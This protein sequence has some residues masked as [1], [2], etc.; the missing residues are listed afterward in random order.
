M[1]QPR[2]RHRKGIALLPLGHSDYEQTL[3]GLAQWY[4][5]SAACSGCGRTVPVDRYEMRRR[6]GENKKV[7]TLASKLVCSGCGNRV[8][9]KLLI[10]MMPRD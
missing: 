7:G 10:G 2:M 6:F 4:E 3:R 9:N 8:G 1:G 5:L